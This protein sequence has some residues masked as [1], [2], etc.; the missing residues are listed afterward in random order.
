MSYVNAFGSGVLLSTGL[1]HML[2]EGNEALGEHY[3]YPVAYAM[4]LIGFLV[5]Y[6]LEEVIYISLYCLKSMF[7]YFYL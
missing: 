1:M 6:G 5:M 3:E 2:A 4:C 7:S